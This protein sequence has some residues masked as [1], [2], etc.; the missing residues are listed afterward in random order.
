MIAHL[1]SHWTTRNDSE[2]IFGACTAVYNLVKKQ[3]YAAGLKY[4]LAYS[5]GLHKR[6]SHSRMFSPLVKANIIKMIG[7]TEPHWGFAHT[8]GITGW[9]PVL[10]MQCRLTFAICAQNISSL[11][12][13]SFVLKICVR[14]FP[15]LLFSLILVFEKIGCHLKWRCVFLACCHDKFYTNYVLLSF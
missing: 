3:L 1:H 10:S 7:G 15:D 9:L 12:P 8:E 4:S 13:H 11:P 14:L 2:P 5:V 6:S